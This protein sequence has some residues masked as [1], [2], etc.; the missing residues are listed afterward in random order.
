MKLSE[1]VLIQGQN[2]HNIIQCVKS[3]IE[4]WVS[5]NKKIQITSVESGFD[6][7]TI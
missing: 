6:Y 3:E 1:E 7:L 2:F 5:D 4:I